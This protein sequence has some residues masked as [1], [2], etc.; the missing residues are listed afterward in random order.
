[1]KRKRWNLRRT[2]VRYCEPR[3]KP[4]GVSLKRVSR[5][6]RNNDTGEKIE[7]NTSKFTGIF[8]FIQIDNAHFN[9]SSWFIDHFSTRAWL[10]KLNTNIRWSERALTRS[11]IIIWRFQRRLNTW[12]STK[13]D[14][15]LELIRMMSSRRIWNTV[16]PIF[17]TNVDVS[18]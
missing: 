2:H 10:L 12:P 17:W 9:I 16:F 7:F 11:F 4:T 8:H 5:V 1:M 15:L 13:Y 6:I 14:I 3:L 18:L